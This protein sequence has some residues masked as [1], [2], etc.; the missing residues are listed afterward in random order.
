MVSLP[1]AGQLQMHLM[2]QWMHLLP[3]QKHLLLCQ[4]LL[5]P[6]QMHLLPPRPAASAATTTAATAPAEA[7]S[8]A[9]MDYEVVMKQQGSL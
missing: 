7:R 9:S 5:L 1:P 3:R 8:I 6:R 4:M 2:T